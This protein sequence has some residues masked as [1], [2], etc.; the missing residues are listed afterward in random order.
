MKTKHIGITLGDPAGIGPEIVLKALLNHPEVYELCTPVVFGPLP[1]LKKYLTLFG[2]EASLI[3]IND[4]KKA[5]EKL[6]QNDILVFNTPLV[7]PIPE[8]G[9]ISAAGGENSFKAINAAIEQALEKNICAIATAPINKQSLKKTQIPFLDHTAIFTNL[10][11]SHHTMTLF[12]TGNL[13]IFF[14]SRHIP[15][16]EIVNALDEER[17]LETIKVCNQ[18]LKQMG[19]ENPHLAVA[20][21]NPHA[22]EDG[23]F[24][25]E[26]I[27]IITPAIERAR[28]ANIR[29]TGPIP[30]DSVFHLASRGRYEAVLSLYHDQGHIA[31]KTLDFFGTI[32]LTLGLPFLRTSVDHG[33]AFEIAGKGIA[34][35]TSMVE[36]IKAAARYAWEND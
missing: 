25:T 21:L 9:Q 35:E 13:R 31:A 5:P 7:E 28:M 18:Y 2:M 6:F 16:K 17:L 22:G 11:D 23:L 4:F 10:T 19:F 34:N 12:V 20:A 36:A 1:V 27:D 8:P 29:V 30:A 33:T 3:S 15:F 24:G 32:S 26:E 14:Y